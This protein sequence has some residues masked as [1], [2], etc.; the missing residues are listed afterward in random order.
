MVIPTY[1]AQVYFE[2]SL[3]GGD[4]RRL[5]A[6]VN[7]SEQLFEDVDYCD[8]PIK[9]SEALLNS[10]KSFIVKRD[11]CKSIIAGYPWFLDWGRD[12]L[13]SL[14]GIIAADLLNDAEDIIIQYL[15]FEENGTIPN[16]IRGMDSNNRETS[17]A[18]LW[19]FVA[20]ND[21]IDKTNKNFLTKNAEKE[22]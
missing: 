17:D 8:N 18:P 12:S 11:N 3:I 20:C 14:R 2:T 19:L 7:C 21:F 15:S 13:I 10:I 16:M 5:F 6:N 9:L 1:L 4:I 22:K